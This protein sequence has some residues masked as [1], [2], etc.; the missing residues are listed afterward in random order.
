MLELSMH[1][2]DI[3]ENSVR[4]GADKIYIKIDENKKK[5]IFS[6][7]I[8]DNGRGM[9]KIFL[10]KVFDPFTTTK[11]NKK[12]GLGLSLL[13]AAAQRCGGDMI[14]KSSPENGTELKADFVL[15]HI[16]RQPLGDIIETMVVLVTGYS[17]V[18]FILEHRKNN[19]RLQWNSS[20]ITKYLGD[21]IRSSPK[22]IK[23]IKHDLQ[24]KY[25][26]L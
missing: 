9:D 17:Q 14:I 2:I 24:D 26:E 16:D 21:T 18:E 23:F 22:V 13:K 11:K 3:I 8:K 15:S 4:A 25:K 6:I 5:N 20:K 7:T 19:K 12:V 1:I 10:K